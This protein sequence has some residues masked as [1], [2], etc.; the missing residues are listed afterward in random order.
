MPQILPQKIHSSKIH[1]R[2]WFYVCKE[3]YMVWNIFRIYKIEK[4]EIRERKIKIQD[5]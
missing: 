2:D 3:L 5:I 4:Y 1:N